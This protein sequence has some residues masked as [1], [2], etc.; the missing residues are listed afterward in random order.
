MTSVVILR[1]FTDSSSAS[2]SALFAMLWEY[3]TNPR[4]PA[5]S[6]IDRGL[7]S[8]RKVLERSRGRRRLAAFMRMLGDLVFFYRAAPFVPRSRGVETCEPVI[9]PVG[10]GY[11]GLGFACELTCLSPSIDAFHR[12]HEVAYLSDAS[13]SSARDEMSADDVHHADSK[14]LGIYGDVY[15]TADSIASTLPRKLGDGKNAGG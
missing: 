5:V 2:S 13:A 12:D 1:T 10:Q 14:I 15:E 6:G 3:L 4:L 9:A 8:C 11:G 7:K